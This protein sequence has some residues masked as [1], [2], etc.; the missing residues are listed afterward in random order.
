MLQKKK[1]KRKICK[2][3]CAIRQHLV[4]LIIG[5]ERTANCRYFTGR[6]TETQKDSSWVA[7]ES[8]PRKDAQSM[9]T[10]K[11]TPSREATSISGVIPA[12]LPSPTRSLPRAP[13]SPSRRLTPAS[14]DPPAQPAK[15]EAADPPPRAHPPRATHPRACPLGLW[16]HAAAAAQ[17]RASPAGAARSRRPLP[18]IGK[19]PGG[20]WGRDGP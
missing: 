13:G 20:S 8:Q 1:K 9:G 6:E 15:C 2:C 16:V 3:V 10:S 14:Q 11:R 4:P 5:T 7:L 12:L 19:F 17:S 18:A